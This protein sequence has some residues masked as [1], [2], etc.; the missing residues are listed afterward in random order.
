MRAALALAVLIA[1]S[2]SSAT[3]PMLPAAEVRERSAG[4]ARAQS[5]RDVNAA[6]T[7]WSATAVVHIEGM[8]ALRGRAEIAKMYEPQFETLV[9][10]WT[11]PH[12]VRVAESGELAYEIGTSHLTRRE[13]GLQKIGIKQ[14][15]AKYLAIWTR[16]KDGLWRIDA[17]SLTANPAAR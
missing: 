3:T 2:S 4:L 15:S 12:E 13:S 11:E 14:S 9:S 7:F 1:A 5:A 17:L 16:G 10:F 6:L 8:P